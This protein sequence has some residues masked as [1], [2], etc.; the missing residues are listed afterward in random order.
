MRWPPEIWAIAARCH[1]KPC[2]KAKELS[3]RILDKGLPSVEDMRGKLASCQDD[4]CRK[5]V[6]TAYRQASD[7]TI[8]TLKQMALNG[9]L[10]RE[11]LAFINHEVGKEL[12]VSGYRA[13]DKLGRSEQSSWLNGGSGPLSGFFNTELRQKEL[14]NAGLS[15]ADAA[16]YVK[17]EQRNLVLLETAVGAIGA[18]ANRTSVNIVGKGTTQTGKGT[19]LPAGY[20]PKGNSV[21]RPKNGVY[22]NTGKIDA[23]GNTIYS[24]NGGYYTFE[25][26]VKTRVQSVAVGI[27]VTG[28]PP[29]RTDPDVRY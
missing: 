29:P 15:K 13:N 25:N 11:E 24:H 12:A 9:E 6:W 1:R 22:N 18:K 20:T 21:T 5:G 16:Q 10:S 4:S 26:G 27:V 7:A 3:Q 8:N 19:T 23:S 17:E 2:G 14:E 28:Y